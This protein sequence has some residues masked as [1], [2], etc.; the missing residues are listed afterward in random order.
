MYISYLYKKNPQ[1]IN[2][3]IRNA[4]IDNA[5]QKVKCKK[6]LPPEESQEMRIL[7]KKL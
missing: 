1:K 2:T 5:I 4:I 6:N 7:Q 3:V